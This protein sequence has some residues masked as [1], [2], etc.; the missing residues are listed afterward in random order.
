MN[1]KYLDARGKGI[2]DYDYKHDVLFFKVKNREY[3]HSIEVDNFVF[4]IDEVGYIV[5][6][7]IFGASK[8]FGI[9]KNALMKVLNWEF[10]VKAEQNRIEF[11]LKFQMQLRN[12]II[13]K[14]PIVFESTEESLKPSEIVCTV[15]A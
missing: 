10:N 7:Q 4:D 5:G 9:D 8:M 3:E 2:C 13:E 14:N 15:K 12:K 1:S 11:N 6:I